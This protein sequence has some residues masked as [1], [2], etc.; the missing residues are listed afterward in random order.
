MNLEQQLFLV[1]FNRS[2]DDLGQLGFIEGAKF[3]LE[4]RKDW[5]LNQFKIHYETM[6]KQLINDDSYEKSL[7]YA[8]KCNIKELEEKNEFKFTPENS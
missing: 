4:H 8:L 6:K 7:L 1:R 5:S 2:N 3:C